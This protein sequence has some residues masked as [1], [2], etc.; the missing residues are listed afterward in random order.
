MTTQNTSKLKTLINNMKPGAVILA[1]WL[2][3]SGISG[4]LQKHYRKS[5]WLEAVG[6]GAFKKPED[7]I[8]WEGA[9]YALQYQKK[10]KIHAGAITALSLQGMSHYFRLGKED[11]FLFG[12]RKTALPQWFLNY[13]WG[14]SVRFYQTG[15]LP[16]NLGIINYDAGNFI[17]KISSPERAMFECLYLSPKTIDLIECYQLMEG[18]VNLKPK[19]VKQLLQECKSVKVKRLFLFMAEKA[20]HQWMHFID[21]STVDLGSGNRSITK[22]GVYLSKYQIS[23]PR[24]LMEI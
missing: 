8:S 1:S 24:E 12:Q 21:I 15:F 17:I 5:G 6:Y 20:N 11:L 7:K 4:D 3:E 16:P 10:L 23:V 19:L 2:K 22:E 18:L 13:N 9:L 14:Y